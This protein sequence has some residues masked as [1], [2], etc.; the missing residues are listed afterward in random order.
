M[1]SSM[2]RTRK[3]LQWSRPCVSYHCF[4]AAGFRLEEG[5]LDGLTYSRHQP[6]NEVVFVYGLSKLY[7]LVKRRESEC[8]LEIELT[9]SAL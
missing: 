3:S 5:A 7:L 1:Y 6:S 4:V 2:D 8:Q 9:V